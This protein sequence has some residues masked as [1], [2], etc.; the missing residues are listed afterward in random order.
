MGSPPCEVFLSKELNDYY[1]KIGEGHKH[2]KWIDEMVRILRETP[3]SGDHIKRRLI[4][5]KYK[6]AVKTLFRYQHP[7]G[8]RS[9]FTLTKDNQAVF[10]IVILEFL[11][12]KQYDRL[13]GYN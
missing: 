13:F 4:P 8:Y 12:H 1:L 6:R 3:F 9:I 7:E 5:L 10:Q 2:R 11:D